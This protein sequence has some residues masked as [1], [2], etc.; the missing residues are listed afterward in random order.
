[1]HYY[2]KQNK[3]IFLNVKIFDKLE[4]WGKLVCVC[5][6]VPSPGQNFQLHSFTTTKG[7]P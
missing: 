1:M 7:N 6:Y 4:M 5:V 2:E 3:I